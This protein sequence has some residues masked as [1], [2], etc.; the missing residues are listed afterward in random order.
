VWKAI[1][2]VSSA[3]GPKIN[4]TTTGDR[5]IGIDEKDPSGRR[6]P[7]GG[8]LDGQYASDGRRLA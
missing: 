7:L 8:A 3:L 4:R 6:D 2:V 5:A 1:V